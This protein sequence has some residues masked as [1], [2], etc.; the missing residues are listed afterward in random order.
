MPHLELMSWIAT[1]RRWMKNYRGKRYAVSPRQLG[2]PATKEASRQGANDWWTKKQAEIDGAAKQ[3][4]PVIVL[5]YKRAIRHHRVYAWWHRRHGNVEEAAKSEEAIE[6]LQQALQSD[7][8]PF[9][10]SAWQQDP[11]WEEKKGGG[12]VLLSIWNAREFEYDHEQQAEISAP[13]A[14]TIKAHIDQYLDLYKARRKPTGNWEHGR[15][16][17]I[18]CGTSGHGWIRSRP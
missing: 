9:P 11:A 12:I 2:T 18:G 7:Y 17:P 13:T 6:W 8:P 10:L 4:P 5:I 15:R 1:Q 14:N 3:H 16:P